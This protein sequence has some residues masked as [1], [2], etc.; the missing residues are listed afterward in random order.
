MNIVTRKENFQRA[1]KDVLTFEHFSLIANML[2]GYRYIDVQHNLSPLNGPAKL[3]M[4]V[5][6]FTKNDLTV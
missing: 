6:S 2:Y 4:V 5:N 3:Y 1:V